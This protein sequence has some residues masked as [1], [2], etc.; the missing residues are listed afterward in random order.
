MAAPCNT[1]DGCGLTF[2]ATAAGAL[3]ADAVISAQPCN[4]IQC[5]PSGLFAVKPE[6]VVSAGTLPDDGLGWTQDLFDFNGALGVPV[7]V[8]SFIDPAVILNDSDCV[9]MNVLSAI[10][11][12]EVRYDGPPGAHFRVS[13]TENIN[14]FG[15]FP[16]F[17]IETDLRFATVEPLVSCARPGGASAGGR[18]IPA[19]GQLTYAY[20][21]FLTS[22]VAMPAGSI[23]GSPGL[24]WCYWTRTN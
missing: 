9:S 4:E 19:G 20:R 17:N 14:G 11:E 8:A 10:T 13:V 7:A 2:S 21:I 12:R 18:I 23:V 3:R 1:E 6:S 5:L 15:F 24:T 22:F 16:L